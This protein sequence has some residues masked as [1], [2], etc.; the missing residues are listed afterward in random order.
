MLCL[1]MPP[2]HAGELTDLSVLLENDLW[3][4]K[5]DHWYTNGVRVS[6]AIDGAPE[7]RVAELLG[8]MGKA[9]SWRNK[10]P[11]MNYAVGQTM[12]T[13]TDITVAAPQPNDRPWGG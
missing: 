3:V 12:Y 2:V 8:D 4:G 7:F 6:W 11:R 10:K 9:F 1:T 13:P 5:T